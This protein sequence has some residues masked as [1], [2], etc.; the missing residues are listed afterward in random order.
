MMNRKD[1]FL[2]I[3]A[4]AATGGFT[5]LDVLPMFPG[6][7]PSVIDGWL[8]SAYERGYITLNAANPLCMYPT[9]N[10]INLK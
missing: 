6:V 5:K 1:A 2:K 3:K 10:L 4:V 9:I 7:S 8:K